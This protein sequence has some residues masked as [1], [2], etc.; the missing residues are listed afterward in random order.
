MKPYHCSTRFT[1]MNAEEYVKLMFTPMSI[2]EVVYKIK[3]EDL[4]DKPKN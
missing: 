1:E 3:T 4:K 2:K